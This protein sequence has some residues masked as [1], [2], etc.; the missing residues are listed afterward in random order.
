MELELKGLTGK[1]LVAELQSLPILVHPL[2]SWCEVVSQDL[3]VAQ[4]TLSGQGHPPVWQA[5]PSHLAE[6]HHFT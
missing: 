3:H 1:A 5:W 2:Q 6:L 4:V